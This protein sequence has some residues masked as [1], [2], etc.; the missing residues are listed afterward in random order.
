MTVSIGAAQTLL[1][2]EVR[3]L[4]SMYPMVLDAPGDAKP[5]PLVPVGVNC[6]IHFYGSENAQESESIHRCSSC[7]RAGGR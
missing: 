1:Q 4:S 2:N 5:V 6:R 3:L 7:N